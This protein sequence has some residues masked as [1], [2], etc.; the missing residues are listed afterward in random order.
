MWRHVCACCIIAPE[1]CEQQRMMNSDIV[2]TC[3]HVCVLHACIIRSISLSRPPPLPPIRSNKKSSCT[4]QRTHNRLRNER[5]SAHSPTKKRK[6]ARDTKQK[7]AH[8]S[9][10]QDLKKKTNDTYSSNLIIHALCYSR[11]YVSSTYIVTR[12]ICSVLCTPN[13]V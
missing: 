4:V 10:T 9:S 2:C 5:R 12:Q 8:F 6:N 3:G 1:A 11:T 7:N 13:L